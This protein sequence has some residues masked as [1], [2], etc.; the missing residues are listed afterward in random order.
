MIDVAEVTYRHD[1]GTIALDGCSLTV[2]DGETVLLCGPNGSGKTT[3]LQHLNGLLTPDEGTVTV[4]GKDA[5]DHPVHARTAVGTVFQD[6]RDGIV[7]ATA[8]AD[9][10]FGPEN[11]GLER[12]EIDRRVEAAL[13]AVGMRGRED[14]RIEALS[15]GQRARVAVAGAL[16]MEPA[17]LALDEPFAGLDWPSA[18]RLL[19]HL[20]DLRASGVS[21]VVATHDLRDL[22][23]RADRVVVLNDGAV[24]HET[25]TPAPEALQEFGVRPW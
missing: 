4:D 24:V 18:R 11:L 17:H 2:A 7:A 13:A 20:D 10:A 19:A 23:P 9:A 16:A 5:S 25:D 12:A 3:L 14:D 15:G 21:L 22:A 8:G 6:P 1:E